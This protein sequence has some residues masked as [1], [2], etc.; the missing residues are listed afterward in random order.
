MITRGKYEQG[1]TGYGILGTILSAAIGVLGFS[2]LMRL[3]PAEAS[4]ATPWVLVSLFILPLTYCV[5]L[6]FKVFDLKEL[7][8][9]SKN[10]KRRLKPIINGKTRQLFITI[11]YYV[12]SAIL[13]VTLLFF[14]SDNQELIKPIIVLIGGLLGISIFS[15]ALVFIEMKEVT[16]F[17]AKIKQRADD[18][19][20]QRS[21]L[22]RL[23]HN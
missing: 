20:N 22:K 7:T 11:I 17:K 12:L 23:N 1:W 21:A 4:V 19:K 18:K 13:V 5:Q 14:S 15:M 3:I 10:E 2:G 9:L 6:L 16:D 8:G